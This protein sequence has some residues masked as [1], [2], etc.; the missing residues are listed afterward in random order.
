MSKLEIRGV[1]SALVLFTAVAVFSS[2][3]QSRSRNVER[4]SLP[5]SQSQ[6]AGIL[7]ADGGDPVP[8]PS[9]LPWLSAA[10]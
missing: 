9:P 4:H 2:V 6:G 7:I 3:V 5:A 1:L 8:P 10:A